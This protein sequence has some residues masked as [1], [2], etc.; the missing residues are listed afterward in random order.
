[1][2]PLTFMKSMENLVIILSLSGNCTSSNVPDCIFCQVVPPSYFLVSNQIYDMYL[3]DGKG[4]RQRKGI[5][6]LRTFHELYCVKLLLSPSRRPLCAESESVLAANLS[7]TTWYHCYN[8]HIYY[9]HA[10]LHCPLWQLRCFSNNHYQ[11]TFL[12]TIHLYQW[13]FTWARDCWSLTHSW[14]LLHA[15]INVIILQ[16]IARI[17]SLPCLFT[18]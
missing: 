7:L 5:G 10:Y 15:R 18:T 16:P 11:R 1:V 14:S 12:L 2:I 4:K 8:P 13:P 9:S 3:T 6:L 17:F